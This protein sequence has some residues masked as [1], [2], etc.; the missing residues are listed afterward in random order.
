MTRVMVVEDDEDLR[1]AVAATLRATGIDVAVAADLTSADAMLRDGGYD[2][3]VFDRMLPDGDAI[4]YVHQRRQAGWATPVLFLTARDTLADR[5][6]GFEHGGDDYLVKPFAAAE[7]AARVATLRGRAGIRPSVLRHGGLEMDCA[8][9]E[10]RR[11]GVLLI[12]SDKEFAVLEFLLT[13][14]EQVVE[15]A[16]L[17]EHCWDALTD[18]MSNVVDVVIKRL[19]R[20]LREPEVIHTVRGRGYRLGS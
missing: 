3:V 6:A 19:R 12:L 7:L 13:R 11:G 5:V 8:R 10:V 16:D 2:C 20:K 15:R 4:S 17:I 18:P 9:R 14:A 1:V